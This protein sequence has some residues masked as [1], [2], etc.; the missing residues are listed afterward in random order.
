LYESTFGKGIWKI[1]NE[2]ITYSQLVNS[3]KRFY[4]RQNHCL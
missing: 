2:V 3:W 1:V 4:F